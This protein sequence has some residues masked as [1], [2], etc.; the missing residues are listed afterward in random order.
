[1]DLC[2]VLGRRFDYGDGDLFRVEEVVRY[3]VVKLCWSYVL[4]FGNI[5]DV[6]NEGGV[7][8]MILWCVGC[9]FC[10]FVR[11]VRRVI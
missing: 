9:D 3:G 11:G 1:M 2:F 5:V 10:C 8:V 4:V 6:I 7:F